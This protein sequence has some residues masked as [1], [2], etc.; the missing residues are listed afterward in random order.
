RM[1]QIFKFTETELIEGNMLTFSPYYQPDGM[2]SQ[3]KFHQ[4]MVQYREN[5]ESIHFEWQ[6]L[7]AD[8]IT[9]DCDVTFVPIRIRGEV[10]TMIMV[11]DVTDRKHQQHTIQ[12]Q[13]ID[14]NRQNHQ[15][16]E[17]S[18]IISH[19]FR[20][21]V[22]NIQ[23]L[24]ET[25]EAEKDESSSNHQII[26]MLSLTANRLDQSIKDLH[27]ILDVQRTQK[28]DFEEI[29]LSELL[30]LVIEEITPQVVAVRGTIDI[31]IPPHTMMKGIKA[32]LFSI[33]YNLLSNALKYHHP[34]RTPEIQVEGAFSN[35][36]LEIIVKDNG[37]GIDLQRFRS[38]VFSLYKRFHDHVEGK[39]L[40]LYLV[41][42]QTEAMGGTIR[43][44]S[45]VNK[46]TTFILRF[47]QSGWTGIKRDI[48]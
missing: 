18:Y 32:Y 22:A 13:V 10:L 5:F 17:F 36:S 16:T 1:E 40:G 48:K 24:T 3:K 19:N 26:H 29:D 35:S 41:K 21:S 42:A 11:L 15:L 7:D 9:R 8:G 6:F 25:F 12:Q 45:E 39:G 27:K 34:D 14:L 20:S 47:K 38:Q 30:A 46:G 28:G 23:G 44:D 4:L 31:Q 37:L 43:L 2:V 33:F